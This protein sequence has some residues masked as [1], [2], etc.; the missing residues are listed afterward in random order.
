MVLKYLKKNESLN[1][2]KIKN[3]EFF[4]YFIEGIKL[5]SF[6]SNDRST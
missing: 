5:I 1:K 4:L 6:D 3:L 2:K